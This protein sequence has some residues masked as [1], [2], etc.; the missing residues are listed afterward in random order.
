MPPRYKAKSHDTFHVFIAVC[1][2]LLVAFSLPTPVGASPS[3]TRDCN[4][5]GYVNA[6]TGL[7][8][9]I[10]TY[11]G[12]SCEYRFCPYGKSWLAYP[13]A[14]N[15]RERPRVECSNMGS[16]D[17]SS[18]QC[19]CRPGYEGRACERKSCPNSCSGH[20]QCVTMREHA[21]AFDGRATVYPPINYGGWDADSVMG[22]E[23]DQGYGGY[24]CSQRTCPYGR[25]PTEAGSA[26]TDVEEEFVVECQADAGYFTLTVLGAQTQPIPYDASP[27][28]VQHALQSI[29]GVGR[30]RVAMKDLLGDGSVGV[31]GAAESQF[32]SIWFLDFKGDRPPMRVSY[33]DTSNTRQWPSGQTA[34]TLASG[35]PVLTMLS[36][37]TISCP[38]CSGCSGEVYLKFRDSISSPVA[39]SMSVAELV[40][41]MGELTDLINMGYPNYAVSGENPSGTSGICDAVASAQTI[42]VRSDIGNIEPIDFITYSVTSDT[43]S[44][45]VDLVVTGANP[46]Q[47]HYECSNQGA[48]NTNTGQCECIAGYFNNQRNYFAAGSDG[49]GSPG[50]RGDCGFLDIVVAG[51]AGG[52]NGHGFC[53]DV[54]GTDPCVCDY[55]WSGYDCRVGSCPMGR[56]WFDEAIS[57]TEAHQLA[58][59]SNMGT[60]DKATGRCSCAPGYSGD[61]CQRMDCPFSDGSEC[62]GNGWCMTM[63]EWAV[64]NGFTYGNYADMRENPDTW[65]AFMIRNCIC[66]AY[67][68][69]PTSGFP[70]LGDKRQP[71]VATKH[72]V[73][74][75]PA[76][77]Q[78]LM[79]YR[80]YDCSERNCPVGNLVT[81][82][83]NSQDSGDFEV[84]RVVCT[85]AATSAASFTLVVFGTLTTASITGDMTSAEVETTIEYL[86]NVGNVTVSFPHSSSDSIVTACSPSHSAS[87]GG[88]LVR[89]DTELGDLPLMT[90]AS[91]SVTI[92]A[93]TTGTKLVSECSGIKA[94]ICNRQT[95]ECQCSGR[96][97][98]SNGTNSPGNRGDCGYLYPYN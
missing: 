87:S 93:N 25:D 12:Y 40:T 92:T 81:S 50:N 6:T 74:G 64:A 30:V 45:P 4:K 91:G 7:C 62:N 47:D 88:F 76:M 26:A 61:A 68:G 14:N 48:C 46:P 83:S 54:D 85:L 1:L 31:C 86:A 13:T 36:R 52:C 37:F 55:G 90:S 28:M 34:L 80:G 41:A 96:Y 11:R 15:A 66:S 35:T 84:Q 20:G 3:S 21:L 69:G 38:P 39:L 98:S 67:T 24:D 8:E 70:F 63:S 95:G 59:C 53:Q 33:G 60:C 16:C 32:T 10:S 18:G 2:F 78:N 75:F 17:P 44:T 97:G 9:C 23:C 89:F 22:C 79:G 94:G 29:Y 56:A 51:C 42:V 27:T 57:T 58:T 77:T 65:D 49:E 82:T 73:S 19:T 72:M 5:K 43:D 71:P